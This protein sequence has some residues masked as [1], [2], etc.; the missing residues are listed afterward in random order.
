MPI[1]VLNPTAE[2]E[3]TARDLAPRLGSLAGRR[4]G[5]LDNRKA[6]AD[7]LFD[8]VEARL[9]TQHGVET[10]V[11]RRKPDFSRPAPPTMLD[12]LRECDAVITGVGD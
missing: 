4:V 3:L 1:I 10:F 12:D 7:R 6:N 11:R 5:L 9:R 2:S 8:L